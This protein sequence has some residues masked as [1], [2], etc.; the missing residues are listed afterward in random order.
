MYKN[1]QI[2]QSQCAMSLKTQI[3]F[4]KKNQERQKEVN[5]GSAVLFTVLDIPRLK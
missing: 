1:L 5:I 2:H 3:S 4:E